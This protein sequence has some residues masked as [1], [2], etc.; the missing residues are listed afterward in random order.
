MRNRVTSFPPRY[1][2][3]AQPYLEKARR[4][5]FPR[6]VGFTREKRQLLTDL[7]EAFPIIYERRQDHSLACWEEAAEKTFRRIVRGESKETL[8]QD[9]L[10]VALI[11]TVYQDF[12]ALVDLGVASSRIPMALERCSVEE[13][14]ELLK[15]YPRSLFNSAIQGIDPKGLLEKL[16]RQWN[17]DLQWLQAHVEEEDG[18]IA[19]MIVE[20]SYTS[21]HDET[22]PHGK[23][24]ALLQQYRSDRAWVTTQITEE[25]GPIA[26]TIARESFR[27][28]HEPTRL[29]YGSAPRLLAAFRAD[30]AWVLCELEP[31]EGRFA[32]TIAQ[33]SMSSARN[34]SHPHGKAPLY[35]NNFRMIRDWV[36]SQG[37]RRDR[38]IAHRIATTL[39]ITSA[40]LAALRKSAKRLLTRYYADIS[41]IATQL[42]PRDK[43]I[44]E[45]IARVSFLSPHDKAT[46]QGNAPELIARFEQDRNWI[47]QQVGTQHPYLARHIALQSF[48]TTHSEQAPNGRAPIYLKHYL[49]DLAWVKSQ[50]R[51]DEPNI[52]LRIAWN[53]CMS[54][55]NEATP[56]G[57]APH[58]LE[59]FRLAFEHYST[60][61]PSL[62]KVLALRSMTAREPLSYGRRVLPEICK[63]V[64]AGKVL[65]LSLLNHPTNSDFDLGTQDS[66]QRSPL[67]EL[68]SGE[69]ALRL[70][71]ALGKLAPAEK[72]VI[73]YFL[74]TGN[75]F[76]WREQ[77]FRSALETLR[78]LLQ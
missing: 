54:A 2:T 1:R 44:A 37:G 9:D 8:F 25:D 33:H 6:M 42:G 26:A 68:A 31:H 57:N 52:A 28:T 7:K 32:S 48:Q 76:E 60:T 20:A 39:F 70:N 72:D 51:P 61:L 11:V 30:R 29:P 13:V 45:T 12:E 40:P 53:S 3:M 62:A 41:W 10:L 16:Q 59:N 5:Y 36:V 43:G 56:H 23:A 47:E 24:P 4:T 65:S 38:A 46:P 66:S 75:V 22:N 64:K 67:E 69:E 34:A 63:T 27:S 21:T 78:S 71:D 14:E 49:D 18:N 55:H 50:L 73:T 15:R 58:L 74:E 17:G 77:Q 19:R 35:L